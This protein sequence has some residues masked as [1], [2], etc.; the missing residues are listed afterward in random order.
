MFRIIS[1]SV[2]LPSKSEMASD[3]SPATFFLA[4]MINVGG[5]YRSYPSARP[6]LKHHLIVVVIVY[7]SRTV[8]LYSQLRQER[9]AAPATVPLILKIIA[10]P[11]KEYP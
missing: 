11:L 5:T 8:Q 4:P 10:M 6:Y 7:I 1:I 2:L 3:L 9:D